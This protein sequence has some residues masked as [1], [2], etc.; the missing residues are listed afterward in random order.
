MIKRLTELSKEE[1]LLLLRAIASGEVDRDSL[2]EDSLIGF[3]YKDYFLGLMI[4][5]NQVDKKEVSIVFFGEAL[6]AKADLD[7]K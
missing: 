3:E 7:S 1:K 4:A 6:K 2:K 5:G